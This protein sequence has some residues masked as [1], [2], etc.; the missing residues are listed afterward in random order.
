VQ[1]QCVYFHTE[2]EPKETEI[3]L[4]KEK[5]QILFKTERVLLRVQDLTDEEKDSWQKFQ[6]EQIN[7]FIKNIEIFEDKTQESF[8]KVKSA[9]KKLFKFVD[10]CKNDVGN[11]NINKA[12]GMRFNQILKNISY[13][14][15]DRA[16][17]H[18]LYDVPYNLENNKI[19]C[20]CII[21]KQG[22]N[23]VRYLKFIE[24]QDPVLTITGPNADSIKS[25]LEE[26]F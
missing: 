21:A 13:E 15:L 26:K 22:E 5:M 2:K 24:N 3:I 23:F 7:S 6:L 10:S 16:E 19:I 20:S 4:K 9:N 18:L 12:I 1:Q 11:L 25:T 17:R 8:E 14:G